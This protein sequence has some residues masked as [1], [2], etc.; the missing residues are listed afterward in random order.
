MRGMD[1]ECI[2]FAKVN[3]AHDYKPF[4]VVDGFQFIRALTIG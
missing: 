3:D 2:D 1:N 4:L